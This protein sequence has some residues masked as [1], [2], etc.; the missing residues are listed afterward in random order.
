MY[1]KMPVMTEWI[2]GRD[3]SVPPGLKLCGIYTSQL[4]VWI[5]SI[6]FMK[7]GASVVDCCPS[8]GTL[9]GDASYT[10]HRGQLWLA[11]SL[12]GNGDRPREQSPH[13]KSLR[14]HSTK[15][16]VR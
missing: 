12:E 13:Q 1:G 15:R 5:K 10:C 7:G 4:R 6:R 9:H 2:R 14:P 16:Y 11:E 3:S 8:V